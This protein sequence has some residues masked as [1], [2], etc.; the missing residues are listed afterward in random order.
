[1]KRPIILDL[2][3]G[4]G[5]C[6]VGYHRAGFDVVGVDY[7]PMKR[8]PFTFIRDDA[9]DCLRQFIQ[10]GAIRDF[11]A[12]HAS[13]PCQAYSKMKGQA[14]DGYQMLI[15]PTRELLIASGL[16]YVIE[17]VDG[18]K[19]HM[20]EPIMLK[21]TMFGLKVFR[22]RYFESN[23][24]LLAPTAHPNSRFGRASRQGRRPAEGEY[25]VV[26]G[27]FYQGDGIAKRAMGID[28]MT[29]R[30]MAQAIPPAY[31]EWIGAQLIQHAMSRREVPA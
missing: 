14:R 6:S 10:S 18:A 8:Y 1:M 4:E 15:A 31:T 28:W 20:R 29:R 12:I 17:N 22:S 16:P 3:C 11:D 7:K 9:L 27:N 21:G 19:W 30:G 13:P 23:V 25:V 5:G 26:T 2:Y 24:L